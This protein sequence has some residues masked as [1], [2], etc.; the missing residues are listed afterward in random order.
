M[1][2]PIVVFTTYTINSST[3]W[4]TTN[5]SGHAANSTSSPFVELKSDLVPRSD[6][7]SN[8]DFQV[9]DFDTVRT[10]AT[11][12]SVHANGK[13]TGTHQDTVYTTRSELGTF[14]LTGG[15]FE[16]CEFDAGVVGGSVADHVSKSGVSH[17]YV[18]FANTGDG[19][20]LTHHANGNLNVTASVVSGPPT[21]YAPD[22]PFANIEYEVVH[23]STPLQAIAGGGTSP[24]SGLRFPGSNMTDVYI[25]EENISGTGSGGDPYVYRFT[26]NN[27]GA[28]TGSGVSRSYT[29]F[30]TTTSTA[31]NGQTISTR[32]QVT[33]SN[34]SN[35]IMEN[36]FPQADYSPSTSSSSAHQGTIKFRVHPD[37]EYVMDTQMVATNV[38]VSSVTIAPSGDV[39]PIAT[40]SK[41]TV[42]T[43]AEHGLTDEQNQIVMSGSDNPTHINGIH[44]VHSVSNTT[45]FTYEIIKSTVP[46]GQT[47]EGT[48]KLQ[49]YDG[50][51]KTGAILKTKEV[52]AGAG[53]GVAEIVHGGCAGNN[54]V[55][56]RGDT[57]SNISL[58]TTY[59]VWP[60]NNYVA[61]GYGA[62]IA[63][64]KFTSGPT[65]KSMFK[66]MGLK[67]DEVTGQITSNGAFSGGLATDTITA[68]GYINLEDGLGQTAGT[69]F[70]IFEGEFEGKIE[71]EDFVRVVTF[72]DS[73]LNE[74]DSYFPKFKHA[75]DYALNRVKTDGTITQT[76]DTVTIQGV[77]A[78]SNIISLEDGT[79]GITTEGGYF[80]IGLETGSQTFPTKYANALPSP[81]RFKTLE[82]QNG[83]TT[84]VSYSTSNSQFIVQSNAEISLST[85]TDDG[86]SYHLTYADTSWPVTNSSSYWFLDNIENSP[87][88]DDQSNI[89]I[90]K[91]T[92]EGT[93]FKV[94]FTIRAQKVHN[95]MGVYTGGQ[96][97]TTA[98]SVLNTIDGWGDAFETGTGNYKDG[99]FYV[100]VYNNTDADRDDQ[101]TIFSDQNNAS[102]TTLNFNGNAFKHRD[103]PDD[104]DT[105]ISILNEEA[106][107]NAYSNGDFSILNSI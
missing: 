22:K 87:V 42:T 53:A 57:S 79:G 5:V 91:T 14:S 63:T 9:S 38:A 44:N 60:S 101:I 23:T 29:G 27:V 48:F 77:D 47:A 74:L 25:G 106:L 35:L 93:N 28:R 105:E 107:A 32:E 94:H 11:E 1:G 88:V 66:D 54:T 92:S 100:S 4:A 19:D 75:R 99:Y 16:L 24:A 62:P 26:I 15:Q 67:L 61:L 2:N 12:N 51:D 33:Y 40:H 46:E 6:T 36:W 89:L 65:Y 95:Q 56:L 13:I 37:S 8:G 81:A 72:P 70:V 71:T 103:D 43:S 55:L 68:G 104:P 52:I 84:N 17:N 49:T 39:G 20:G 90:F 80:T 78:V 18:A 73:G 82:Y 58:G 97:T 50:I 10:I 85:D 83:F 98:A 30:H 76:G 69:E 7:F 102:S 96:G 3:S 59:Y 34:T 64:V 31:D 86:E 41:V 45:V 21:V